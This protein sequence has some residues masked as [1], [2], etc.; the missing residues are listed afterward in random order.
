MA[1]VAANVFHISLP[2]SKTVDLTDPNFDKK[3]GK[4]LLFQIGPAHAFVVHRRQRPSC[5]SHV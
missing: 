1:A 4:I 2:S 5:G 3:I